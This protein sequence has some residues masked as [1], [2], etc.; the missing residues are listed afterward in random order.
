MGGSLQ[1]AGLGRDAGSIYIIDSML[2]DLVSLL[3]WT[4]GQR[5]TTTLAEYARGVP[6]QLFQ[7]NISN[8]LDKL[9]L[10]E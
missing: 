7:V 6:T 2:S 8:Y 10:A 3:W 1:L 5:R 4:L 9:M